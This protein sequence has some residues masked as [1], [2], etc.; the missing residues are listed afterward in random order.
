MDATLIGQTTAA[1]M[2]RLEKDYEEDDTAEVKEV[3]VI[4]LVDSKDD[5]DG[6]AP[7]G[8]SVAEWHT[9]EQTWSHKYGLISAVRRGLEKNP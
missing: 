9:S 7:N 1:F 2:E 3:I 5:P 4:A 8:W 6:D